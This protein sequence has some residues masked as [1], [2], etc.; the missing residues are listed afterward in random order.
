M[1]LV[2]LDMDMLEVEVDLTINLLCE[3][4]MENELISGDINIW[5]CCICPIYI[6]FLI[7]Y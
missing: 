4:E 7:F 3:P 1:E 5:E 2:V 6:K